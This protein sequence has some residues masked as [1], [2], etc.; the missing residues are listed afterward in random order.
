MS[1]LHTHQPA[2]CHAYCW[3][4]GKAETHPCDN[5]AV[6]PDNERTTPQVT[7]RSIVVLRRGLA[8]RSPSPAHWRVGYGLRWL[9]PSRRRVGALRGRQRGGGAMKATGEHQTHG[10]AALP[11]WRRPPLLCSGS[12]KQQEAARYPGAR[13]DVEDKTMTQGTSDRK[14]TVRNE[15]NRAKDLPKWGNH[16]PGTRFEGSEKVVRL[17]RVV[18]TPDFLDHAATDRRHAHNRVAGRGY[19]ARQ[20]H[21]W[22]LGVVR[23]RLVDPARFD[24]RRTIA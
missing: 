23:S 4:G 5:R 13:G 1:G 7:S 10:L 8:R 17:F 18:R 16:F 14:G 3:R 22:H 12:A 19:A 11:S 15:A 6:R 9:R 24:Q 2:V 21:R 20:L